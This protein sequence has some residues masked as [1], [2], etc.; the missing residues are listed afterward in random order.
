VADSTSAARG[1]VAG[2][3]QR[4]QMHRRRDEH[5]R[6]RERGE[7]VADVA[8]I[9]R[10]PVAEREAADQREQHR[11][12]EAVHVL[13]RHGADQRGR[14]PVEQRE[15]FGRRAHAADQA[16]PRLAMRHRRAAR[17]RREHV[18]DEPRRVDL[19]HHARGVVVAACVRGG[20]RIRE[21]R[22]VD[23]AVRR[24][25]QAERIG[26]ERRELAHHLRRVRR[27]QQADLAGDERRAQADREAVAIA[28]HVEHVAA[29][30]QH[31]GDA[32]DVRDERAHADGRTVAPGDR[33]VRRRMEYQ[34]VSRH[35]SVEA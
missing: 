28:A 16:A 10:L 9:E 8:R 15:A 30:G 27:R 21:A 3:Q 22:Q 1:S 31:G 18:R 5:A 26:C 23:R 7:F 6:L 20:F 12:F 32:C 2:R 13:R 17:T 4:A 14:T 25:V 34:R 35:K 19:R 11:R 29:G 24:I 33:L